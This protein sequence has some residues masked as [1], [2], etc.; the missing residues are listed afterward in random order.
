[1]KMKKLIISGVITMSMM[2]SFALGQMTT[3]DYEVAAS[4]KYYNH[5]NKIVWDSKIDM[6]KVY[7]K[8]D[9]LI[10]DTVGEA[11]EFLNDLNKIGTIKDD[12]KLSS[13]YLQITFTNKKVIKV[14]TF[15][16]SIK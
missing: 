5:F 2:G 7:I 11:Q 1:M 16:M 15:D 8:D 9:Y 10:F 3:K 14:N 12:K 4:T 13:K 6:Y